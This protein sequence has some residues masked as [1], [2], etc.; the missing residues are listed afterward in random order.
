MAEIKDGVFIT[1]SGQEFTLSAFDEEVTCDAC[2]AHLG[3]AYGFDL[4]GSY[5]VCDA[6]ILKLKE[7]PDAEGKT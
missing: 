2:N 6:C 4:N 7:R 3:W 5:F 1:V